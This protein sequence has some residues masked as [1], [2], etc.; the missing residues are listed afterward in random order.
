M[1][2]GAATTVVF[3]YHSPGGNLGWGIPALAGLALLGAAFVRRARSQRGF[4]DEVNDQGAVV[5]P[6][7]AGDHSW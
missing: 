2:S 7:Q 1:L 6:A 3:T 5:A 4:P